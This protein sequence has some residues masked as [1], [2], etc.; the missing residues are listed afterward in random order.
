MD[1]S[2]GSADKEAET[3]VGSLGWEDPLEKGRLPTPV[4]WPGEFHG[5]TSPWD[6]ESDTPE[7]CTAS[8]VPECGLTR[9]LACGILVPRPGIEPMSPALHGGFLTT[10]PPGRSPTLLIGH[11]KDT[12]I[13]VSIIKGLRLQSIPVSYVA[14]KIS[15]L[16]VDVQLLFRDCSSN[17]HSWRKWSE[18]TV[19]QSCPTLCNPM[20]YTVHGTFQARILECVAFPFSRVSSQPRSPTLLVESLPSW[21]N[22][23]ASIEQCIVNYLYVALDFWVECFKLN[24]PSA[25]HDSWEFP[26][27]CSSKESACHCRRHR[28]RGF[29][30]K[31]NKIPRRRKWQPTPVFLPVESSGQWSLVGYSPWGHKESDMTEHI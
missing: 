10:G 23:E 27:W 1:F 25:T 22:R 31:V 14:I 30:P 12:I 7:L 29:N 11:S 3:W 13:N 26:R 20:S 5:L 17:W 9:S 4:F 21:V 15:H 6:R 8:V 28:R 16:G 2:S 24:F 19:I 18:L